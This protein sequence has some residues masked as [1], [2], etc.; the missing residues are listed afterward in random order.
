[1]VVLNRPSPYIAAELPANLLLRKI[2]PKTLMP[3]LLT[4][5]G[6]MVTLQGTLLSSVHLMSF[7]SPEYIGF[8]T[9]YEVLAMVRAFLGL[10]E[11]PMFPGIVLY[12]S[13]F[14]TRKELSLR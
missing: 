4:L 11:G 6:I 8:V 5:W 3:T 13:G 10:L 14:Y 12:L 1:L 9:S 7:S 2:G